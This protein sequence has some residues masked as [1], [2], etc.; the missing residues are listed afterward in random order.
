MSL[1]LF[2]VLLLQQRHVILA[3]VLNNPHYPLY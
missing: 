3:M 1:S 2:K